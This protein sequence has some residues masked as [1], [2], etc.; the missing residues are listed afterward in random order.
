MT[1]TKTTTQLKSE[2][3]KALVAFLTAGYP[4]DNTFV[5]L[6]GAA[7]LAG[8]DV[9]EIGIPFSDP[10]ADGPVI[11]KASAHALS[12]GMT[13]ARALD[14][15]RTISRDTGPPLV[16]MSYINPILSMGTAVFAETAAASGVSGVILPDVPLEEAR[17]LR[18]LLLRAGVTPVDLVAPTSSEDRIAAI[19]RHAAGFL[20]LVSVAGVTG[21]RAALPETLPA[22]IA[23]VRPHT[24][25]PLYVG[26]GVSTPAQA[27][28][29]ARDADG[30]VIGSRIIQIVEDAGRDAV[31]RVGEFLSE[32]REALD[33]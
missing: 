9:V 24:T 2:G 23:R 7:G 27:A 32:V 16:A 31:R 12:R 5:E 22:F 33:S 26:F 13:L 14:L 17:E 3:R 30:V 15:S 10:I 19:A 20:Y 6:V 21:A 29:V 25:V 11:Q 28:A 8:C 18:P 1:L 4:D